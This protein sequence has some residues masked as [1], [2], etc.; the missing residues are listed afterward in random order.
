MTQ[1]NFHKLRSWLVLLFMTDALGLVWVSLRIIQ[2]SGGSGRAA[3]FGLSAASLLLVGVLWLTALGLLAVAWLSWRGHQKIYDLLKWL[4]ERSAW[5]IG[6]LFLV[7]AAAWTLAWTPAERFGSGYYYALRFLPVAGWLALASGTGALLLLVA[8]H[9]LHLPNW[10]A[11]WREQRSGLVVSGLA[12]ASFALI[13]WLASTRI[14]DVTPAEEDFWYG[15]GVPVLAWQVITAL[16]G[17]VATAWAENKFLHNE[18]KASVGPAP[19]ARQ[20]FRQIDAFI[21]IGLW[22]VA[23]WLWANG[24]LAFNFMV[25]P[26][27]PPNFEPYPAA[28]GQNYDLSSQFALIGQGLYDGRQTA[29]YFERP[30]YSAFL[31]YLHLLTGQDFV[32]MLAFQ[33][34]IFAVFPALAYLLGQ[35]LHSRGAGIGLAILLAWRGLNGLQTGGSLDN[36]TQK[37]FLTDFLTALGLALI[38]LLAIRW[39]QSPRANWRLAGWLSGCLG[40]WG[41]VRPHIFLLLPFAGLLLI[42]LYFRQKRALV[43]LAGFMLASYLAVT[44]PWVQ[45]NGS[46]VSLIGIYLA[47]VQAIINERYPDFRI[48]GP[49]GMLDSQQVASLG[50]ILPRFEP[51]PKSAAASTLDHLLNNLMLSALS[52]PATMTTLDAETVV[53]HSETFWW[54]YWDG[55]L[56]PSA[57]ALLPINLTLIALG[58]GQAWKR[59]RLIGLFPLFGMFIYALI[60]SLARTSGGRYLVPVDWVALLYYTLGLAAVLE[61]TVAWFKHKPVIAGLPAQREPAWPTTW[62]RQGLLTLIMFGVFGSLI[63]LA[64]YLQPRRYPPLDVNQLAARIEQTYLA[65]LEISPAEWQAFITQPGAVLL[66]GRALYPRYILRG[67][68][69]FIPDY[70][71]E[72]KPY[73]RLNL[74]VIGPHGKAEFMMPGNDEWYELPHASDVLLLGCQANGYVDGWAIILEQTGVVQRRL[75]PAPPTCPLPEPVC[76]NNGNCK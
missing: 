46:G 59:H 30:L 63:P 22:L 21:F 12:G 26:L 38:V 41:F 25:S 45:L 17:G 18:K 37:M 52:L 51:L 50:L 33:A 29:I 5:S 70:L 34:A 56:S 57:R 11:A 14:F 4:L 76:D 65:P 62:L 13:A 15:A 10:Q 58:L 61:F 66:E 19:A 23:G 69:P 3:A 42:C 24:P 73:G 54:P 16:L 40:L 7:F 53:R 6:S 31:F 36:S 9:G 39:A 68:N 71:L 43:A 1:I 67:I 47:R 28:D 35:A 48:P 72:A 49:N 27:Y 20:G 55:H 64:N 32:R 60:N 2:N 74:V 75:P 44:M 8:Q